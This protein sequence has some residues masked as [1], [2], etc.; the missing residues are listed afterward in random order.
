M[1]DI[2]PRCEYYASLG[3]C[4]DQRYEKWMRSRCAKTCQFCGKVAMMIS[5]TTIDFTIASPRS[6][7]LNS[8][9]INYY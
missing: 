1:Q 7:V 4:Q 3:A 2:F 8:H 5:K 6:K 9:Y